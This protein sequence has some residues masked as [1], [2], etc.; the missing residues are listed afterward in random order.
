MFKKNSLVYSAVLLF[1]LLCCGFFS[2]WLGKELCWDLANYHYYNPYAFFHDRSHLDFWPTTFIHQYLNPLIDF[3]TYFLINDFSPRTTEFILGAIHGINYWLLFLMACFFIRGNNSERLTPTTISL[4]LLLAL[5]GMYGPTV[6]P[7]IGSFQNDNTIS[8]FILSCLLLQIFAWQRYRD[9]HVLPQKMLFFSAL[10]LGMC[11][12]LKLTA[13]PFFVG[14]ILT[15]LLLPLPLKIKIKAT[16]LIS[17][18][19]VIG[20]S[21]SAGF[22]MWHLWQQ[23]HN[24]FFP[25]LNNIFH[26]PEIT[27]SNWRDPRFMPHGLLQTLF[28]PFYFSWDGR[29]IDLPFRD[30][31]FMMVYALFIITFLY[32]LWHKRPLFNLPQR[33]LLTFFICSYIIWQYYFSNARYLIALEMCAPIVIYILVTALIHQG[34]CRAILL[35][36]LFYTLFFFMVNVPI[37]RLP[38]F[39]SSFFAVQLPQ[40]IIAIRE[41]S[42]LITYSPF[43]FDLNPRPLSYLIPF[44]PTNWHFIGIPFA[45]EKYA[46]DEKTHHVI[47]Q[48][49]Q[50][51]PQPIYLLT[52]ADNMTTLYRTA[53][54][55]GLH[56]SGNCVVIKSDRQTLAN[57]QALLCPVSVALT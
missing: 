16:L 25:F 54:R 50:H 11:T 36:M 34:Y 47:N 2:L 21:L 52:A 9:K 56:P 55:F 14:L 1:S 43:A 12:G 57:Q 20:M 51:T 31:R 3:L 49:I 30:F 19:L 17:I 22:W 6:I 45:K 46:A 42:V 24:P 7:G 29:T 18:A 32:S 8:L 5:L 53:M 39:G 10:L 28:Y 15:T 27:F 23:H 33:F 37:I 26:S 4:G 35:T 44:F 38:W 40:K 41:A 48:L 13:G